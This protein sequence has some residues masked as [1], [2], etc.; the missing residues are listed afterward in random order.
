MTSARKDRLELLLVVL[1]IVGVANG[2]WMLFEPFGW[3]RDLPAA[4]PEYG[5]FNQHFVRD[6]GCAF[7][8]FGAASI[9]AGYR[10]ALRFALVALTTVF[11]GAHA[12]VHVHNTLAGLVGRGHVLVDLPSVYAPAAL[13]GALTYVFYKRERAAAAPKDDAAIEAA[14]RDLDE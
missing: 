3:Y 7:I 1:G 12:L 9:W 6:I 2:V 4:V 14:I 13:L 10:P 5:P 8:A 11:Y